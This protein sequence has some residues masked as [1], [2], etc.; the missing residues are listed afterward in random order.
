MLGEDVWGDLCFERKLTAS[1]CKHRTVCRAAGLHVPF[2]CRRLLLCHQ[3][4]TLL[5]KKETKSDNREGEQQ[6]FSDSLFLCVFTSS[7]QFVV[8]SA[9][10]FWPWKGRNLISTLLCLVVEKV[11]IAD[12]LT[13]NS[14]KN[15]FFFCFYKWCICISCFDM[16]WY[17]ISDIERLNMN[18][19]LK[20]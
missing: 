2:R 12:D 17:M 3:R 15:F 13:D 19:C 20:W 18:N 16:I 8:G 5:V 14:K 7:V 10:W 11:F 1:V 4:T 9:C 6:C